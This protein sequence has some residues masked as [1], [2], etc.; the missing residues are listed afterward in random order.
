MD[1]VR[2]GGDG[3]SRVGEGGAGEYLNY[4]DVQFLIIHEH[5]NSE[6]TVQITSGGDG[7]SND[8]SLFWR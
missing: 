2:G 7:D 1:K 6:T 4:S 3:N 5:I 8:L